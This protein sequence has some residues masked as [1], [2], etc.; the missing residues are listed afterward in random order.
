[1]TTLHDSFGR[2]IRPHPPIPGAA[3]ASEPSQP[4]PLSTHTTATLI[5]SQPGNQAAAETRAAFAAPFVDARDP[6]SP[7]P[8]RS[9]AAAALRPLHVD[10]SGSPMRVAR[11][12]SLSSS[13]G[14]S[15][16][17]SGMSLQYDAS[18]RHESGT[19][20]TARVQKSQ[21]RIHFAKPPLSAAAVALPKPVP[22]AMLVQ[23]LE[24]DED[25]VSHGG[26]APLGY[27]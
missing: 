22:T 17:L 13:P 23:S 15:E 25:A 1:V 27:S 18:P 7:S 20:D 2:V 3:S 19:A 10:M 8:P 5:N 24:L 6:A 9:A 14:M 4:Q 21:W 26:F 12:L 16:G 11:V